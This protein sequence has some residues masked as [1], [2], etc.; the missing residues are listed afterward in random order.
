MNIDFEVKAFTVVSIFAIMK[1]FSIN[2][3]TE[4]YLT[5]ARAFFAVV[6]LFLF[7]TFVRANLMIESLVGAKEKKIEA[8]LEL[9]K[10]FSNIALRAVVICIVHWKTS[11]LP[12]LIVSSVVGLFTAAENKDS[13]AVAFK[14]KSD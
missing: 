10:V 7:I 2:S 13:Y 4:L 5:A 1:T 8:R 12:P 14:K 6:H 3:E 9:R 11:M